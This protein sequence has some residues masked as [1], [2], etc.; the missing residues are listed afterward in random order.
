MAALRVPRPIG[1]PRTRP[2][3]VLADRADSSRAIREHLR[4]RGIR[5]AIPQPADRKLGGR[6]P[7]S[8]REAHKHRNTVERCI[9]RLGAACVL[10]RRPPGVIRRKRGPRVCCHGRY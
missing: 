8:D 6:P 5:S 7:D 1:W 9:R 3:V 4:R 10:R 2:A